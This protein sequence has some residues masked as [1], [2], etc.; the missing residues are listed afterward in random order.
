MKN[1]NLIISKIS[2]RRAIDFFIIPSM[3]M[4]YNNN[5][6]LKTRNRQLFKEVPQE[7]FRRFASETPQRNR[8]FLCGQDGTVPKRLPVD[9]DYFL[10]S[11][12]LTPELLIINVRKIDFHHFIKLLTS[13]TIFRGLFC[14]FFSA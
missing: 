11:G 4:V 9:L 13:F 8:F 12:L 2:F 10:L 6:C 14:F 1:E 5:Q 7:K 3:L